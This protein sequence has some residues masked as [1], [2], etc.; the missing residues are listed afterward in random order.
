ML[1]GDVVSK[2]MDYEDGQMD[3]EQTLEFFQEIIDSGLVWNLQG[4]Y[5]RMANS[6]IRAGLCHTKGAE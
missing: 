3:E 4:S 2:I 5:G 6:L 1:K